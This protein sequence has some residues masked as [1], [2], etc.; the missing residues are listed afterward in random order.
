VREP[1]EIVDATAGPALDDAR[2]MVRMHLG[3]HSAAHDPAAVERVVAALPSPYLPPRGGLWVARRAGAA[4]GCI[5]LHPL[6]PTVAEVKRMY[7]RG[8]HRGHG[9]AR[10]L[11]RHLVDTARERGYTVL[12]LGTLP[13]MHAAQRLYAGFG[14]RPIPAYR[15]VELGDT[16]FYELALEPR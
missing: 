11:V 6:E 4:A 15:G 5:A 13:T 7:V 1:I 8:E 14:F 10:A 3:A 16:L 12:R 9:V 2:A